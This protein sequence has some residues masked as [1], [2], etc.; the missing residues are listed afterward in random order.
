MH[1]ARTASSRVWAQGRFTRPQPVRS[2]AGTGGWKIA[3]ADFVTALMAL[4]LLLWITQVARPETRAEVA[5][6]FRDSEAQAATTTR[7][8]A[9]P[10]HDLPAPARWAVSLE[11]TLSTAPE[12]APFA[13]TMRVEMREQELV[14]DLIDGASGA[15]FAR[16]SDVP[17][18]QAQR[19]LAR[20]APPVQAAGV[21][22]LVEGHTDAAPVSDPVR[23][24][25]ALGAARAEAARR[26]LEEAG[27]GPDRITGVVGRADS[28]LLTGRDPLSAEQR[29]IRLI[30]R[31]AD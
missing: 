13:H 8:A 26:V 5:A 21:R 17:S 16:G 28:E 24:N 11:R 4:F 12:L 18:A 20:L 15:M 25:W 7:I 22:V 6:V 23:S 1:D 14:L 10:A 31:L 2:G 3:Y 27:L 29:R 19:L 30:L 9:Q